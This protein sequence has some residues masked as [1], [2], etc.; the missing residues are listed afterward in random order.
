[1]TMGQ[2]INKLVKRLERDFGCTVTS[3]G[4]HHKV[5]RPGCEKSVT[6]SRTPNGGNRALAN[7]KGDL[8]RYLGIRL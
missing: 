8:K 5:T 2:E 1:M 3:T 7:I 4:S 6:V